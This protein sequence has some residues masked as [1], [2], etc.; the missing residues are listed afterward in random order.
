L[1]LAVT[2][3]RFIAPRFDLILLAISERSNLVRPLESMGKS[4]KISEF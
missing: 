3:N 1:P 4:L 2:R